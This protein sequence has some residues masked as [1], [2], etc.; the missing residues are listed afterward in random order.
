MRLLIVS[1]RSGSGKTSALH[2]LEDE[3][4][5]CIDNLPVNLLP[6]LIKQ[7]SSGP[8]ADSRA[9]AIGID[10]RNI[11][12]DLSKVSELLANAPLARHQYQIIFLDSANDVLLKRFSETRRKHPLSNGNTGLGEAVEKE[13]QILAPIASQADLTI[14]TSKFS[15]HELRSTIKQLVVGHDREG[16]AVMLRSF[17]YKFGIPVDVDFIFD[18]RCLPNPYWSSVLRDHSGLEQAVIDY[19]DGEQDVEEMYQDILNYLRKWIPKF[20][21]NNRSYLTVAIGCTGGWHRSV[22][23]CERLANALKKD[24]KNV[25]ARHRQVK[26]KAEH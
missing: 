1:G 3:G 22:Y 25:Q 19:L 17:G 7:I 15:L 11:I 14:D 9:F 24:Y 8:D 20:E 6:D 10:A 16:M 23:M 5:T 26:D 13:H 2:L 12:G 21:N 4:F 18:V